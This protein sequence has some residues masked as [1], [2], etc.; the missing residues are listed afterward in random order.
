MW[1]F[2]ELA[3]FRLPTDSL[4]L[5]LGLLL[6]LG[7]LFWAARRRRIALAFF[8]DHFLVLI[9]ATLVGGRLTNV[10]LQNCA[11][12][13]FPFFWRDCLGFDFGG[14]M[15]VFFLV[16]AFL[17]YRTK[18]SFLAWADLTTLV[19]ATILIFVHFGNFL[20]GKNYGSPTDLPWGVT[21][22]KLD[23][24][25]FTTLPIHPVQVYFGVLTFLAAICAMVIFKRS[26]E[27]G[28]ASIFLVTVLASGYFLLDF[29]RGDSAPIWGFLRVSQ[30]YAL[31]FLVFALGLFLKRVRAR[32]I[33][34]KGEMGI[35]V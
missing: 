14:G 32:M 17:T 6:G 19:L 2:L 34:K 29:L 35:R 25:V 5:A 30:V 31:I 7:M 4:L 27:G 13:D 22:L 8:A 10:W 24:A 12:T 9:G 18:E 23:S 15:L 28:A 1:P 3:S 11:L 26:L 21:S 16:L 33:A 20:V